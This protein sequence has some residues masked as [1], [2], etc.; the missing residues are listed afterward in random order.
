MLSIIKEIIANLVT[1]LIVA[2]LTQ[3]INYAQNPT[4]LFSAAFILAI[5]NAF[6]KPILKVLTLPLNVITLGLFGWL[7]NVFILYLVTLFVP[8]FQITSFTLTLGSITV[9]FSGFSAYLVIALVISLISRL[10]AWILDRK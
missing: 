10:V 1:F 4:V 7:I 2:A 6:L 9:S 8:Q 3:G 5:F